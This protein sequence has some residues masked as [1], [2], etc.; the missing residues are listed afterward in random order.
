MRDGFAYPDSPHRRRHGPQGYATYDSY[1][2]WLRDEFDYRCVFCLIREQ[3]GRISGEFDV[4]H[5]LP[6]CIQPDGAEDYDNLL[7][8]CAVC[9]GAKG[10]HILPDPTAVLSAR[11]IAVHDDGTVEGMS[12]D[13]ERI[14]RVLDLNDEDYCRWRRIWLR[15]ID[16]A[17]QFDRQLYSQLLGFPD[18]LP[19]LT[20]LRPPGGN[21]RPAGIWESAFAKRD[22]GELAQTY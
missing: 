12:E 11:Q 19:D 22:R 17:E 14:I 18:D 21:K 2:P 20:R 1:R 8:S 4:D 16:L 9:N 10:R 13:A 7:Y 3:W 5:Y 6:V 15:I